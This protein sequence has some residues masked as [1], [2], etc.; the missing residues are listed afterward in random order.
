MKTNHRRYF[1]MNNTSPLK[2]GIAGI[3]NIK[4]SFYFWEKTGPDFGESG[5]ILSKN[6][7]LFVK[8]HI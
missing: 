3:G 6:W 7:K 4:T 1:L 5:E 8:I 2:F